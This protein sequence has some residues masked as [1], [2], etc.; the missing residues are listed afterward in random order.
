MG[1][2][3]DLGVERGQTADGRIDLA[4]A[5]TV[6][7]MDDLAL[8]VGQ[9][10]G[11][12]IRQMQLADPG[13]RQVQRHRRAQ[14]AEADDQGA[15][16]FQ[17]QLAVDVDLFQQNLSAIAQQLLVAQHGRCPRLMRSWPPRSMRLW[18]PSKP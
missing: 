8:Q 5:D 12:E 16:V 3:F 6:R 2:Q 14:A 9:V 7:V 4:Q 11:V 10:D 17:A 15:T 13:R 18:T 1:E